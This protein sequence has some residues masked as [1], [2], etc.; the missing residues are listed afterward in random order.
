[1]SNQDVLYLAEGK[2]ELP[3]T[4]LSSTVAILLSYQAG[5]VAESGFHLTTEK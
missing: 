5:Y 1:M 2:Y 3:H 4:L